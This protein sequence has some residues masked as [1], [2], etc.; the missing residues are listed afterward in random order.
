MLITEVRLTMLSN[1]YELNTS[2]ATIRDEVL[3]LITEVRLT[4]LI[5]L[6]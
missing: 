6:V 1:I 3:V 4:L 2:A 5:T